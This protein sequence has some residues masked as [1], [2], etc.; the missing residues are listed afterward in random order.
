MPVRSLARAFALVSTERT[1]LRGKT[2][3]RFP[4]IAWF[5]DLLGRARSDVSPSPGDAYVIRTG[6]RP[7]LGTGSGTDLSARERI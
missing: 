3:L 5:L 6:Y 7:T 1:E 4:R 2:R